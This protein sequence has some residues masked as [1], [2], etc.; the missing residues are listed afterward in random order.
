MMNLNTNKYFYLDF[1]FHSEIIH[2]KGISV[3]LFFK[4]LSHRFACT[5]SGFTFNADDSGIRTVITFLQVAANLNEC[6][7]LHGHHDRQ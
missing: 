3:S 5:M 2:D 6:A 1:R 4:N 7:E